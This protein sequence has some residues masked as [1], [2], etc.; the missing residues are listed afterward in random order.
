MYSERE[1]KA[2]GGTEKSYALVRF[3]KREGPNS[4]PRRFLAPNA[5]LAGRMVNVLSASD[6]LGAMQGKTGPSAAERTAAK[7]ASS[8]LGRALTRAGVTHHMRV[9]NHRGVCVS[10]HFDTDS[11]NALATLLSRL[12]KLEKQLGDST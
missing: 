12:R 6:I 3:A 10:T 9:H 5:R 2:L 7:K 8:R 4:D 1:V 11:A